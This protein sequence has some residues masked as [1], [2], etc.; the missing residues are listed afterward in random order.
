ML[1]N[2]CRCYITGRVT[3]GGCYVL[4][5]SLEFPSLR[6]R[7]AGG[8]P[9]GYG[10]GRGAAGPGGTP[11]ACPAR[12]YIGRTG[13]GNAAS[14][15]GLLRVAQDVTNQMSAHAPPPGPIGALCDRRG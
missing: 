8:A 13:P 14:T 11:A 1:Y 9:D 5:S 12:A 3:R 10:L 2:T 6:K 4:H 15:E 7:P